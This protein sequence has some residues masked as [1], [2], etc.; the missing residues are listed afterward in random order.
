MHHPAAKETSD[1][2][3]LPR[4]REKE[5]HAGKTKGQSTELTKRAYRPS[6]LWR[7]RPAPHSRPKCR[8]KELKAAAASPPPARPSAA[9]HRHHFRTPLSLI[10][11]RRIKTTED[12]TCS[13]ST[14]PPPP[15]LPHSAAVSFPLSPPQAPTH[16]PAPTLS[17][18]LSLFGTVTLSLLDLLPA[19]LSLFPAHHFPHVG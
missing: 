7:H 13:P 5:G 14:P 16:R 9:R 6:D 2:V 12:R 11:R 1:F 10:W 3:R 8:P 17:L 15:R 18:S 19:T 4:R